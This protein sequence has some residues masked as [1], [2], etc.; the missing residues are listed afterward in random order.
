MIK[1]LITGG[2]RSGKSEYALGLAE[3]SANRVF[4]ATA[5]AKD[6]EMAERIER[7]KLRRG[8]GWKTVEEPLNLTAALLE[9]RNDAGVVVIDCLSLW[10]SNMILRGDGHEYILAQIKELAQEVQNAAS[11]L[12]I[13]TN[14]VGCGVVPE[15]KMA[16]AFR[17]LAG[18]AGQQLAC[19]CS[20]VVLMVAGIPLVIK[21]NGKRR[22]YGKTK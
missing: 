11:N 19:V 6:H 17:D 7:H 9:H 14:E 8:K 12:I 16:R 20:L 5:E 1:A 3:A 22:N 18:C 21:E 15:N 10:L 2:C 13:V 4:I